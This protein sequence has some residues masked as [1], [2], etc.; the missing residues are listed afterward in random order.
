MKNPYIILPI[1]LLITILVLAGSAIAAQ[2]GR[3]IIIH[4]EIDSDTH[5]TGE[6]LQVIQDGKINC[7]ILQTTHETTINSL[8]L[9]CVKI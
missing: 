8:A 7:Y 1:T 5:Q 3:T 2:K 9:S 4:T 6:Q